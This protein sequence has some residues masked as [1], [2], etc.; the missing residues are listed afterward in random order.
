MNLAAAD[1]RFPV[2]ATVPNRHRRRPRRDDP[3]STQLARACPHSHPRRPCSAVFPP[4]FTEAYGFTS[5]PN[6]QS[7]RIYCRF[8]CGCRSRRLRGSLWVEM[9]PR[10]P[11]SRLHGEA[12]AVVELTAALLLEFAVDFSCAGG[13]VEPPLRI[14]Q[15][16]VPCIATGVGVAAM[17]AGAWSSGSHR[18]IRSRRSAMLC[19]L[20][21]CGIWCPASSRRSSWR[22]RPHHTSRWAG[23]SGTGPSRAVRCGGAGWPASIGPDPGDAFAPE[24]MVDHAQVPLGL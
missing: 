13:G 8:F 20:G 9:R 21:C 5:P 15:V 16:V 22:A 17:T 6:G 14:G 18:P 11:G 2:L 7:W 10:R 19:R 24:G 1:E 4:T 12:E 23:W 3:T